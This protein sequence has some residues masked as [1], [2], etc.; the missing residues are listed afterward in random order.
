MKFR[1]ALLLIFS[2]IAQYSFAQLNLPTRTIGNEEY[3][4]RIVERK[5]S[6]YD[7]AQDLGISKETIIKYNPY[8][9]SGVKKGQCLYFPVS[10]FNGE[11]KATSSAQVTHTVKKGENAYRISK[12]YGVSLSD[13]IDANPSII[14][15]V[16][17]GQV[18]I[19]P[20]G[21]T[22]DT[23]ETNAEGIKYTVKRGETVYRVAKE[24]NLSIVELTK[25][26]PG[27]TPSNFKA[28]MIITIP[29]KQKEEKKE[30]ETI[31]VAEKVNEDE[32]FEDIAAKHNVNVEEIKSANPDSDEL[33][34][35]EYVYVPVSPE[36]SND[37]T[38]IDSESAVI[39]ST[40]VA[41][42]K[43][44]INI[45]LLL[46]VHSDKEHQSKKDKIYL[47][48]YRG[49]LLAVNEYVNNDYN[50]TVNA[51]DIS[52]KGFKLVESEILLTHCD[53][54]LNCS[55]DYIHETD[56]L[57]YVHNIKVV[58]ALNLKNKDYSKYSNVYQLNTPS[59]Q[60]YASLNKAITEKFAGSTIVYV[61]SKE[62][63][64]KNVVTYFKEHCTLPHTEVNIADLVDEDFLEK[65]INKIDGHVVI[66]PTSS[67]QTFLKLIA[68]ILSALKEKTG[69]NK[70]TMLGY[71][72][73]QNYDTLYSFYHSVNTVFHTRYSTINNDSDADDLFNKFVYWYGN[74]PTPTV[75]DMYILGYDIANFLVE[76][77]GNN[78]NQIN[79]SSYHFEGIQTCINLSQGEDIKG[80][81]NTAVFLVNFKPDNTIEKTIIK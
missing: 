15:G 4:Y 10:K 71:P 41:E 32:T 9:T 56:S 28:G 59:Q 24:H 23:S 53:V 51:I 60:M 26:N 11:K 6:I 67:N 13:L 8:V 2:I 76:E 36:A 72:E 34:E 70:F 18:L 47:D 48:F 78:S 38:D 69:D 42:L 62:L 35:G 1:F 61:A 14:N 75:P 31:F 17:D 68:P 37:T 45:T 27:I 39:D 64:P 58:N 77:M 40:E 81:A 50:I 57:G 30:A 12:N 22:A 7:I 44:P 63:K 20:S 29:V 19:I 33:K 74:K 54:I 43:E 73:W 46:P 21:E 65:E 25:A 79:S 52:D 5:E 3:Y 80:Y 66:I 16:K 49:F 55:D